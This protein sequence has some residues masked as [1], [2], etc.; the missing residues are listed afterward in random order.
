MLN[1]IKADE[2]KQALENEHDYYL[3]DVRE[4]MELQADKITEHPLHHIP[5]GEL[6]MRHKELP[7][8]KNIVVICRSG[9]RSGQACHYLM[10]QGYKVTNLDDGML[11]WSQ[12]KNSTT[13]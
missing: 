8:D 11:A 9:N 10:S 2:L 6:P 4:E 1:T 13:N 7:E 3:L 12:T 5:M